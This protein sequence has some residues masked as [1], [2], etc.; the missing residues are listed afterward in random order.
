MLLNLLAAGLTMLFGIW[1]FIKPKASARLMGLQPKGRRGLSEIR[2]MYGG[3]NI[4]LGVFALLDQSTTAFQMLAIAFFAAAV[5]RIIS[6]VMDQAFTK[7]SI[8]TV[9]VELVLGVCLW[10]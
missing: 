4:G 3:V 2:A 9:L 10:I 1:S 8:Q 7:G 5:C 6:L